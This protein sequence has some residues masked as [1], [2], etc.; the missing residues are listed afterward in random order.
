M[1]GARA[2]IQQPAL[3]REK[4]FEIGDDLA[5][6]AEGDG[7]ESF[8]KPF[9]LTREVDEALLKLPTRGPGADGKC[10]SSPPISSATRPA[11]MFS[12]CFSVRSIPWL[13][14]L[15]LPALR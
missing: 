1:A 13:S 5:R 4:G 2:D 15:A 3:L 8:A 10:H 14:D 9:M 12:T 7:V 11:I 6:A